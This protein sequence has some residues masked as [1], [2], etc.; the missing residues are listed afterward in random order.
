MGKWR[1][2]HTSSVKAVAWCIWVVWIS[3]CCWLPV[4]VPQVFLKCCYIMKEDREHWERVLPLAF[5]IFYIVPTIL[6]T[7]SSL[8]NEGTKWKFDLPMQVLF[9]L[10]M[11]Y[12]EKPFLF[13]TPYCHAPRKAFLT[14]IIVDK[15]L[16][17]FLMVFHKHRTSPW[18]GTSIPSTLVVVVLCSTS[19]LLDLP[20]RQWGMV[21]NVEHSWLLIIWVTLQSGHL[22]VIKSKLFGSNPN[23]RLTCT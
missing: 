8:F 21:M 19:P 23:I 3:T 5:H 22:T 4:T 15:P 10:Y 16:W 17:L 12:K 14:V 9:L 6:F 13:H 7:S 11:L 2:P 18:Q 20:V 1:Q